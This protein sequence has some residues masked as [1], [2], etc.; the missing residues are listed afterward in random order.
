MLEALQGGEISQLK[1]CH[2]G[3]CH[4]DDRDERCERD[5]GYVC[6]HLMTSLLMVVV[7]PE[8]DVQQQMNLMP[9]DRG[10]WLDLFGRKGYSLAALQVGVLTTVGFL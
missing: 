8:H 3:M 9:K 1:M 2:S 5:G 6:A 10:K 7:L 4:L